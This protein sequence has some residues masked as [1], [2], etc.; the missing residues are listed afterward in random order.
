MLSFSV[1]DLSK[2][3]KNDDRIRKEVFDTLT[4][5]ITARQA[6]DMLLEYSRRGILVTKGI[7]TFR[8][9][10]KL[11]EIVKD[12]SR[13]SC[14][15]DN[16]YEMRNVTLKGYQFPKIH[17]EKTNTLDKEI[18]IITKTD[19][20]SVEVRSKSPTI[21]KTVTKPSSVTVDQSKKRTRS[22]GPKA[23]SMIDPVITKQVKFEDENV[24]NKP[25]LNSLASLKPNNEVKKERSRS[26][27]RNARRRDRKNSTSKMSGSESHSRDRSKSITKEEFLKMMNFTS[28]F[29][30]D[31]LDNVQKM[32]G[33]TNQST[34]RGRGG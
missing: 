8:D 22:K 14:F 17:E 3:N 5:R 25:V 33:G 19:V 4:T 24:Q 26:A 30:K 20:K 28:D 6:D 31:L 21:T 29:K 27:R 12:G 7:F 10:Q 11:K 16:I 2:I 32:I 34:Y 13:I 1:Y 9:G 18:L 15:V 23:K